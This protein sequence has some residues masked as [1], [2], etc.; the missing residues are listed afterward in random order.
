MKKKVYINDSSIKKKK[1]EASGRL[2]EYSQFLAV[3][4]TEGE[5]QGTS[6]TGL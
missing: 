3:G 2:L 6:G 5:R 4:K 1:M